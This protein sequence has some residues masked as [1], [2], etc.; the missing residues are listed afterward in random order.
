MWIE[1]ITLT[2]YRNYDEVSADFSPNLN[3]FIG[4]NAQGKTNFL[5]AIYFLSL[6]SSLPLTKSISIFQVSFTN[7]IVPCL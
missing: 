6:K 3:V 7:K 1:Q 4:R 2:N 5:E